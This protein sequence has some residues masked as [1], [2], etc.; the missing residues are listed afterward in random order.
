MTYKFFPTTPEPPTPLLKRCTLNKYGSTH[1]TPMRYHYLPALPG[2]GQ[3][4]FRII[5]DEGGFGDEVFHHDSDADYLRVRRELQL[6]DEVQTV[7]N[8]IEGL[9]DVA[10]EELL[11]HPF[12][13][14][15]QY[16]EEAGGAGGDDQDGGEEGEDA[17]VKKPFELYDESA[18]KMVKQDETDDKGEAKG[19]G[20]AK[21]V[22]SSS[23]AT[24]ETQTAKTPSVPSS[25]TLSS[26]SASPTPVASSPPVRSATYSASQQH[27]S[28]TQ[29]STGYSTL[30]QAAPGNHAQAQTQPPQQS[31][32]KTKKAPSHK[33]SAAISASASSS[34]LQAVRNGL[35]L[36]G[37]QAHSQT[38][39][40]GEIQDRDQQAAAD[41]GSS[42]HKVNTTTGRPVVHTTT[43]ATT[44][45]TPLTTST[46]ARKT[47]KNKMP[48]KKK[49]ATNDGDDS[50]KVSRPSLIEVAKEKCD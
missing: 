1:D 27:P 3:D 4:G 41:N 48:P 37:S 45:L 25:S 47:T 11:A 9:E 13:R 7:P 23:A 16:V 50:E 21:A 44:S 29:Q 6:Q 24:A 36:G 42:S 8:G 33:R 19:K 39:G 31:S 28:L 15:D 34:S 49:T 2:A 18:P 10:D 26:L 35:G 40:E 17:F 12:A 32:T 38:P 22:N 14:F 20:K 30:P 5:I 46:P 43:P